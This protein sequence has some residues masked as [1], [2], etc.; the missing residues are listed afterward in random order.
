M[1]LYATGLQFPSVGGL[2]VN[3]K[4]SSGLLGTTTSLIVGADCSLG[5]V[6]GTLSEELVVL[7]S[8]VL[9]VTETMVSL[10]GK[11]PVMLVSVV[12]YTAGTVM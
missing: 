1:T 11:R 3:V 2:I 7:P 4:S 12:G 6:I 5:G 8:A 9:Q 10:P